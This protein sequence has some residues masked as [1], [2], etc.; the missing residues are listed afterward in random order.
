MRKFET[1]LFQ[2]ATV[3]SRVDFANL[4]AV[5]IITNFRPVD[6]TPLIPGN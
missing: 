1:D 6:V 5:L 2:T 3:Q 4:Q